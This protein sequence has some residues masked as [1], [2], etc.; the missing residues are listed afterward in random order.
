[1]R[2]DMGNVA[3]ADMSWKVG[4]FQHTVGS[5]RCRLEGVGGESGVEKVMETVV[6]T[7]E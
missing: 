7:S 5:K 3:G 1:M 4:N 6:E 2:E